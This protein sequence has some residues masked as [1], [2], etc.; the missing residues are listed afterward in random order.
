MR[1]LQ[2][3]LNN[4]VLHFGLCLYLKEDPDFVIG[5]VTGNRQDR[6]KRKSRLGMFSSSLL[7]SENIFIKDY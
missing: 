4:L 5:G 1:V 2:C 6:K 3:F 7:Y